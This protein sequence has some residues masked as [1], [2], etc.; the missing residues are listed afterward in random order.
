MPRMIKFRHLLSHFCRIT[1]SGFLLLFLSASAFSSQPL[2]RDIEYEPHSLNEAELRL[3]FDQI[4]SVPEV[5]KLHNG[6]NF[7]F[8]DVSVRQSHLMT[9]D[10][11]EYIHPIKQYES[12]FDGHS[13]RLKVTANSTASTEVVSH[14]EDNVVS[15]RFYFNS[16]K[17]GD[18]KNVKKRRANNKV[19]LEFQ[20]IPVR[21]VLTVIAELRDF[22]LVVSDNVAGRVSINLVDVDWEHALDLILSLKGLGRKIENNVLMIAPI[23][24]LVARENKLEK[25]KIRQHRSQMTVTEV[26]KLHYA[27]LTETQALISEF[28]GDTSQVVLSADKRNNS[29]ILQGTP[30]ELQRIKQLVQQVDTPAPQIQ[31]ESRIVTVVDGATKAMGVQWGLSHSGEN[32]AISGSIEA[33]NALAKGKIPRPQDRFAVSLPVQGDAPKIGVHLAKVSDT[34]LLD[35]ELSA[36]QMDNLAEVIARPK[37]MVSNKHEAYIE[38]GTE[39][40]F[41]QA[42][43]SGATSVTFKKAVL[44][45]TVT[46]QITPDSHLILDLVVTQDTKGDVVATSTG[47]AVS[48]DT[49][50]ISTQVYLKDGET[51]VLGGIFQESSFT[52]ETKVPFLGDIPFF[53]RF[54][55]RDEVKDTK[56]ELLIFITPTVI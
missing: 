35:L 11:A 33:A 25:W 30:T 18:K 5:H 8:H 26:I 34:E 24:E 37:L 29:L 9:V 28:G 2:L 50:E 4:V 45:L 13:L 22:N 20:D 27:D 31:I 23:D 21:K 17:V 19:T 44:S 14:V 36:M 54:F 1:V 6:Y 51:V 48:I 3:T 47:P 49:Q 55:K 53:G 15:I 46:P 56:R 43:S 42:S 41:V 10:L 32:G 7:I 40:P 39:I 16:A 12:F 52:T 38:Q